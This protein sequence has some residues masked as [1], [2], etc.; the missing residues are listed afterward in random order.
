LVRR[1]VVRQPLGLSGMAG[2]LLFNDL[3][4]KFQHGLV[5]TC[6]TSRAR[7]VGALLA[8]AIVLLLSFPAEARIR[9]PSFGLCFLPDRLD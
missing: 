9:L 8:S 3:F 7:R 6:R 4:N 1:A 2:P 5:S